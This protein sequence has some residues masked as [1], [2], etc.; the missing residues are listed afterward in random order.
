M[1]RFLWYINPFGYLMPNPIHIYKQIVHNILKKP[2]L[3]Y[4]LTVNWFQVFLSNAKNSIQN[5][6][7]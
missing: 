3:I 4:L 6:S 7:F 1:I 2:E 5:Y